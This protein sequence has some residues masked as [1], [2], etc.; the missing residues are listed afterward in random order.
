MTAEPLAKPGCQRRRRRIP[1][2]DDG[3][4]NLAACP[5]SPEDYDG[6]GRLLETGAGAGQE[7][8]RAPAGDAKRGSELRDGKPVP[9]REIEHFMIAIGQPVEGSGH[10]QQDLSRVLLSLEVG[11]LELARIGVRGAD[12][13]L[14]KVVSRRH[15]GVAGQLSQAGQLP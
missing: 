1:L 9:E 5:A 8:T 4:R 15:R 13:I 7:S 2:P 12:H 6:R 10:D 11:D 3:A 14:Q